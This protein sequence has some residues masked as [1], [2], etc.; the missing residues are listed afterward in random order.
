MSIKYAEITIIRNIEKETIFSAISKY[1]FN[2]N[3][4]N[5]LDDDTII[6]SFHDGTICDIKDEYIDKKFKFG[7]IG[8]DTLF[9]IYIELNNNYSLFYKRPKEIN[10]IKQLDFN[11]IFKDYNINFHY[12]KDASEF[13]VIYEDHNKNEKLSICKIKS[14]KKK[15]RFLLA[16]DIDILN[17]TDIIYLIHCIFNYKYT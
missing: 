3:N 9:P 11:T 14:N 1:I 4:T 15:P 5:P 16:Y 2:E 8:Y 13:N 17:K 12:N 7:I 10:G 6:L